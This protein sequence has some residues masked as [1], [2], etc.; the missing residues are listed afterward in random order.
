MKFD[1]IKRHQIVKSS[2]NG[3]YLYVNITNNLHWGEHI[4]ESYNSYRTLVLV[5]RNLPSCTQEVKLFAY[6]RLLPCL[7]TVLEYLIAVCMGSLSNISEEEIR[8]RPIWSGPFIIPNYKNYEPWNNDSDSGTLN[9]TF[10]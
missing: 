3:K 1:H 7:R 4:K 10:T 9:F 5:P 6:E 8:K 2:I